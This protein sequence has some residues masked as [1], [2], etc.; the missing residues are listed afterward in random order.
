MER[1]DWIRRDPAQITLL[2]NNINWSSK[3]EESFGKL[4]AGDMN[5]LKDFKD[6]SILL[7]TDLIKMVQGDLEKQLR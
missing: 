6:K 4:Q 2:V 1:K 5:A 3:V 7:L